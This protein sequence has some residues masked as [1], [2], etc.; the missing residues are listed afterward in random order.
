VTREEAIKIIRKE[1]ACVDADC[2]IERSC[3]ECDLMMPSKEPI[4]RAYEMAI[5]ALSQEP[6]EECK[7]KTFTELYFHTDP[8]M[9]EQEPCDDA[10]SRDAVCDIV[11]DI[12]DCI[13]VEGYWTIIERLKKLPS[14]PQKPKTKIE[15]FLKD[16]VKAM[17]R[18][19]EQEPYICDTCKHKGD[20]WDT[21]PCD[22][23]CGNHSG[24]EPC[25]DAISRNAVIQTLNKMDRYTATELTLCD[26]DKK[27][28]ANEVFIVDDVYEQIAEQ[29]PP[30]TQKSGQWIK[31]LIYEN[32]YNCSKCGSAGYDTF[33]YCP[34]CGCRMVEPQES[35]DKE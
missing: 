3:G 33:K 21:E 27:F 22:G 25:E 30:V 31:S 1:Y 2:D 18:Y 14:V 7:Y 28:P 13:S 34:N 19:A 6:C 10:I 24:Y 35:E 11:E 29:L 15:C 23:C 32:T 8:E 4:L 20:G 26:T 9:V 17:R 5:Q 16:F 12:R